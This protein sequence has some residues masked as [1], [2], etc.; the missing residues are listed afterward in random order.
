[1]RTPVSEVPAA[2]GLSSHETTAVLETAGLAP[3]VHNSQPWAFRLEADVIELHADP[4]RRMPVADPEDHELR[5][6]CGAA[7][8]NLRLALQGRGV[9][10]Q[11]ERFPDRDRPGLLAAVRRA[12]TVPP[13]PGITG[14]LA[15]VPHRRT[16]R[17]PFSAAPVTASE[18]QELCR[19]AT[20]EGGALHLVHDPAARWE[21]REL[22]RRAHR[23]QLADP[24]FR[25][26]FA[27]WTGVEDGRDDGVPVSAGGPLPAPHDPWVLR[28]F[29]AGEGRARVPGKDFEEE[30]L[31]A[32]LTAPFWGPT[33]ELRAGEALQHVL[34]TAT[35]EGLAVSYLSQLVEVPDVRDAVQRLIGRNRPPLVV[36][37]IGRGWPTAPT[38]RRPV[39][40]L[41][42]AAQASGPS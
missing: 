42:L 37:R 24:A 6:A 38:P 2:L 9:V 12:G 22:A 40:D 30:P 20:V 3:S 16:N 1:M 19:V 34:L 18:Q 21:L 26:E 33:G 36:L 25:A 15:A 28:D 7:L 13:H 23:V 10:P 11:V 5:V 39:A 35:V 8:F 41:L 27:R 31:I 4:T 14:L 32:V 29:T 17:R